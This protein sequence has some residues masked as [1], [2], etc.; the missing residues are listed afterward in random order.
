MAAILRRMENQQTSTDLQQLQPIVFATGSANKL[1]EL[2]AIADGKLN[3]TSRKVDLDEI[4]S[5]DLQEI[6]EHKLRQAYG[7][8]GKPV[9]AEDVSAGLESLNGLPGPFIKFFEQQLGRGA[10]H[11]LSKVENDRVTI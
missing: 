3:F 6:I 5:L 8:I 9:I 4:Q 7:I 2:Q 11:T 10:L 1:A